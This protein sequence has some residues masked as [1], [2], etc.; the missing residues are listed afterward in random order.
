VVLQVLVLSLLVTLF[1][2]LYYLQVIAG[3][4]Y[5][6]AAADNRIREIIT[7]A[8]RGLI[9]DDVGRPLAQN[10]TTLVVSVDRTELENQE[11]DGESVVRRLAKVLDKSYDE[12][13]DSLQLCGTEGAEPPPVCWNGSP[14]QPIPVDKDVDAA[15]ALSI[16]ERNELFP[17]VTAELEAVR[18]YAAPEDANAAHVIGYLGPVTAEEVEQQKKEGKSDFQATDLVGRSGLELQYD[19][20]LRGSS[21]VKAL[22][23]D[24]DGTVR[25]TVAET[26]STPGDYVVTNI[27][28][29]L[30]ADVEK[31]LSDGIDR[32][33]ST[34]VRNG[35]GTYK[36]DSAA[37]VVMD[38]QEGKVL[39]LASYPTYDPNVWVGGV[40][41]KE[42]KELTNADSGTPLVSRPVSGVYAPASTFK[43][44]SA[45][46]AAEAGN[47]FY[48]S[49]Q[50]DGAVTIGDR[51]FRNFESPSLGAITMYTALEKS[52]NT[53][54]YNFAYDEWLKDGGNEPKAN[55]RDV[56]FAMTDR[57]GFGRTTGIDLPSEAA[58]VVADRE[59]LQ[60]RWEQTKDDQCAVAKGKVPG[61]TAYQEAIASDFCVE[62]YRLRAGDAV[63]FAIGQGDT[64]STPLQVATA[65][66]AL[67][68][69]GE[70][71]Q[72]QVARAV[73]SPSGEVVEEFE[74]TV[75]GKL[76]IS[77]TLREQIVDA[78]TAVPRSG[79][80]ETA[81]AG[82]P[83]SKIPVA[84]KTGT[85]EGI[86]AQPTAWFASFA[87]AN[88]PKYAVVITINQGGTGG[89][90]AA[91]VARDIYESI[92][93]VSGS[94]VDP[95]K[96]S[97]P[98]GELPEELPTI[99][100]DGTVVQPEGSTK[101]G[102][103]SSTQASARRE[104]TP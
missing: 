95:S 69:G 36:A 5:Q 60:K 98:N 88:D 94:R 2:R 43:V 85:A 7:P 51:E 91:P 3:E 37:A 104:D 12:V 96:A 23:V 68:N 89:G 87:P 103:G 70:L 61:Q 72:P 16:M 30:Q 58:G 78:L 26:P 90:N 73:V 81:F 64:G 21:G 27:D 77:R 47:S 48:G 4:D 65:Y 29:E 15:V 32:S 14:Y 92:F 1:G 63:N 40:T 50:C 6:R 83:L 49:Y 52:C 9:L 10:R 39:A 28:A 13:S 102:G 67:A 54:F 35:S 71:V 84:G 44:V 66:A 25:G 46:A 79:T 62:G 74:P 100:P 31:A 59:F 57:F 20:Y 56:F 86:N 42:Y 8:N 101:N 75:N 24:Q 45:A 22:A 19:Q 93:G 97:L 38:V 55:P 41:Q 76:G 33:R 11:D 17:G 53:V 34:P 80:G 82:F 18:D 99:R